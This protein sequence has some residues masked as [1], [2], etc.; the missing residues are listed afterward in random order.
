MATVAPYG[1]WKSPISA[2]LVAAKAWRAGQLSV[3][4][5]DP[6]GDKVYWTELRPAEGGRLALLRSTAGGPP[7]EVSQ[8][9]MNVRTRVHEYGGVAYVA[10]GDVIVYSNFDD[11]LMYLVD[12]DSV[13]P[14]TTPGMRYADGVFDNARNRIVCVRED[15]TGEGEAKNTIVALSLDEEG[16]GEVLV[17]GHDFY[18]T[19]RIS[20]DGRQLCW[21]AW[22]H[23]QMPWTRTQLWTGE[24]DEA[25]ALT[26]AQCLIDEDESIF[27][28]HWAPDGKL[29]FVSDRSNWWN[30]YRWD[31][32]KAKA[33]LPMNAE[34]GAPQWV[35]GDPT[36]GFRDANRAI[37]SY[38][39]DGEWH[40][41][42][43]DVDA[44]TMKE[45]D[46]PYTTIDDV[47]VTPD[48][49][50]FFG[51]SPVRPEELVKLDLSTGST[52]QIE[53]PKDS[54]IDEKY[55]SIP[56]SIEFPT[57]GG[58]TAHA[59]YYAPHNPDFEAPAGEKPPLMVISHGG[60]TSAT[61]S[62]F[63]LG[64]QFWTTRGFAVLDVN[65]G[66]STGYGRE[67]RQRLEGNW[68][69]VDV[70]D[71]VAG[72]QYLAE[73]GEVD[74]DR[75]VIRGGS[76]GGF[77]TLATLTFRD[78]FRAGA[79]YYGIGDLITFVGDTH[80]FESRYLDSLVGPYP[81][82]EDI[83][84]ERSALFYTDQLSCPIIFFQGLEDKVVPP[85]QAELMVDA[86]RA[87][88]LPVAYLA[89]EGEQH[90][91]RRAENIAR[92]ANAELYFYSK[93]LGFPLAEAIEPVEIENLP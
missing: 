31:N 19:P 45:L 14:L 74:G 3:D 82:R 90:G 66:G 79:S 78:V 24:F 49:A 16:P 18:S 64:I 92:S 61:A 80:K 88:G 63:R 54:G 23:P 28:P 57:T 39:Q 25:G 8:P 47:H 35:F 36:Y 44:G 21:L 52:S 89:Y 32:G 1:S 77:T 84:H 68:G 30:L 62:D 41:A 69:V 43:V 13:R 87:K 40:L 46:T 81:E 20:P 76:A 12:G 15:H 33:I 56:R 73:T 86:L 34:F 83:Y 55:M 26:N 70:D 10:Q 4:T 5:S 59:I 2:Q 37:C 29:Y 93:V 42:E 7:E 51:G 85:N 58:K 9:Q 72:A 17:S 75:M 50:Y 38:T 22:N 6:R 65:Y 11:Q 53:G 48:A 60:P 67:Y 91:F 27:Q 71:C